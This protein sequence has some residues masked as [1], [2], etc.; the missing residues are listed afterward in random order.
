MAKRHRLPTLVLALLPAAA[1]DRPQEQAAPR[2][3]A[4]SQTGVRPALLRPSGDTLMAALEGVL[5]AEGRC[6]YVVGDDKARSRTLPAFHIAGMNWDEPTRTLRVRGR[7][8]ALGQRVV[9]GGGE[10]ADP[11]ALDWVQRPDP[12]CDSSDL[13]M[14]GTIE[15]A[16]AGPGR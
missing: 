11:A 12:T 4:A 1:C 10:A 13:F 2:P 15:P 9:L 3:E 16:K 6:L 7:T 14:T 8:F 5:H